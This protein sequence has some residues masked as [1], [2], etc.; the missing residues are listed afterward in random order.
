MAK[1]NNMEEFARACGVSRPTVS[2]F[3][4]DPE[5]VKKSTRE[6]I[7]QAMVD[8]DYQPNI[9][10]I[11]QNRKL[12]KNIGIMVPHLADP[13]FAE[14][15]RRLEVLC[16]Q[17][18]FQPTM[19]S[20]YGDPQQEV[21]ILDTL[22]TLK[23]AGA[24]LAPL[25]D[26]SDRK[27]LE[28]FCKRVPTVLFDSDIEGIGEAFVGSDNHSFIDQSVEYLVRVGESPMFFEMASPANPNAR[29]RRQAYIA[30]MESLGH[31]PLIE[32]IT[33]DGWFFEEIGYYGA[34]QLFA[35]GDLPTSSVLCSNDRLAMGFMSAAYE[36]GIRIG[37]T[38]SDV[39]R[40][41]SNDDHPFAQFTC[42]SLTTSGHN[43]S[44]VA[45]TAT[46]LLFQRIEQGSPLKSRT[47]QRFEARLMLRNSA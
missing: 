3:F 38:P 44:A 25:G 28:R 37:R 12:T 5:S 15:A 40:L 20:A 31:A 1:I 9:F 22:R 35:R 7:E 17:A 26:A 42:P 46:E 30:K 24:L 14:M 11:N 21:S 19:Y 4:N 41:A 45:K 6:K 16:L 29:V 33:G 10:A 13:F 43:Y 23:P 47:S 18:G 2:K 8:F 27:A 39:L 36:R 32:S 34:Q